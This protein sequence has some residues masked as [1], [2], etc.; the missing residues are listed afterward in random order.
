MPEKEIEMDYPK[1]LETA[2]GD[3]VIFSPSEQHRAIA[4]RTSRR[5]V[6]AGLMCAAPGRPAGK[7]WGESVTLCLHANPRLDWA[8]RTWFEGALSP[9]SKVFCSNRELLQ[10]IG[11]KEIA[12][13]PWHEHDEI[14]FPSS[15]VT[16]DEEMANFFLP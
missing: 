8:Q 14:R 5:I 15:G 2:E 10:E 12:P 7:F 4:D 3:L 6:S 1:Y 13:A 9:T 16:P 11:A